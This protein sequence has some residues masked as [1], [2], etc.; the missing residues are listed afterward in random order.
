MESSLLERMIVDKW[1]LGWTGIA[2][3]YKNNCIP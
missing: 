2:K 3:P 1:N